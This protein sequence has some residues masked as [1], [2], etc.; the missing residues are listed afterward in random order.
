MRENYFNVLSEGDPSKLAFYKNL[1]SKFE[2]S[3]CCNNKLLKSD[4]GEKENCQERERALT[5]VN[6]PSFGKKNVETDTNT[7]NIKDN[8]ENSYKITKK[9]LSQNIP[10]I[11]NNSLIPTNVSKIIIDDKKMANKRIIESINYIKQQIINL[12]ENNNNQIIDKLNFKK[13]SVP[14]SVL[15]GIKK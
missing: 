3:F 8:I 14:S 2:V 5:Q 9:T 4:V 15:P 7:S 6:K 12:I 1:Y 13:A 11:S 10:S